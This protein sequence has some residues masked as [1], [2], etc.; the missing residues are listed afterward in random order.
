MENIEDHDLFGA[1][2][3]TGAGALFTAN[4]LAAAAATER[5]CELL[6]VLC[7]GADTFFAKFSSKFAVLKKNVKFIRNLPPEKKPRTFHVKFAAHI[8]APHIVLYYI[9]DWYCI[10]HTHASPTY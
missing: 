7:V 8:P 6:H 2:M 5:V 3:S 1:A 9:C 10:E 4:R